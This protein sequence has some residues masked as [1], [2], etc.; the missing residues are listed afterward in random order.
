MS[1]DTRNEP[2]DAET[3]EEQFTVLALL[4]EIAKSMLEIVAKI[5]DIIS[6][7]VVPGSV[8]FLTQKLNQI[9]FIPTLILKTPGR[10]YIIPAIWLVSSV[11]FAIL[12]SRLLRILY[13]E[14][15]G[16]VYNNLVQEQNKGDDDR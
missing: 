2:R 5:L 14:W 1:S 8:L 12:V 16:S 6:S 4:E 7:I 3:E 13:D 15:P 10:D 9:T 11:A